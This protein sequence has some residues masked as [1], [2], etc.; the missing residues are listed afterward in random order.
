[1]KKPSV[2]LL[3][4][5]LLVLLA[6]YAAYSGSAPGTVSPP[7]ESAPPE[8]KALSFS[9]TAFD[10]SAADESILDGT[11]LTMIN[12]FEPWC[13]P[14]IAEMPDLQKLSENY[15]S[16]DFQLIG[17]FSTEEGTAAVLENA[18]VTYTVLRYV[19][20]FSRFQTGYVPTT[21]FLDRSGQ[22]VGETVIGSRSYAQWEEII[23]EL[24]G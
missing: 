3:A 18:G 14:C 24:L 16:E 10:G 6:G 2:F 7:A 22:P 1:M 19:P 20:A 9:T 21:V 4:L 5:L 8:E 17:V 15:A 11:K 23:K 13:P 12:F